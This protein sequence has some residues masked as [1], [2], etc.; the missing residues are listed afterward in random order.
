MKKIVPIGIKIEKHQRKK[1]AKIR[2]NHE[3]DDLRKRFTLEAAEGAQ[4]ERGNK[5][6][7]LASGGIY[8][9]GG[10]LGPPE[11]HQR[12]TGSPLQ[13]E[14]KRIETKLFS[15]AGHGN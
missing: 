6:Y 10:K 8:K 14:D 2:E 12:K 5:D 9:D 1:Q 3:Y 15:C 7:A 13:G 11:E 4:K